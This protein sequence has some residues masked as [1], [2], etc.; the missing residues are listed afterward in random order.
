M[1][2]F[3][4]W[5]RALRESFV[6]GWAVFCVVTTIM[7]VIIAVLQHR[8]PKLS[9][10]TLFNLPLFKIISEYQ[11]EIQIAIALLFIVPYIFYAPYKLYRA[12]VH[13]P[14]KV[15]G[16]IYSVITGRVVSKSGEDAGTSIAVLLEIQN[17]GEPTTPSGF[18][19]ILKIGKQTIKLK[20]EFLP[21]DKEF[22]FHKK[23][24]AKIKRS[25]MLYEKL[26]SPIPQGGRLV[27]FLWYVAKGVKM[28]QLSD[29]LDITIIF[30][31]TDENEYR[32]APKWPASNEEIGPQ[33]V[34]G[35]ENPFIP[36]SD[37]RQTTTD[38]TQPSPTP[39]KEA[40][41]P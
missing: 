3:K 7:P 9:E 8:F 4:F 33:Y 10:F 31:D 26:S 38:T 2:F 20:P 5:A 30:R 39:N 22:E 17:A 32:A 15:R 18:E 21:E 6:W 25:E 16:I 35:V 37:H 41:P 12:D 1:E 13:T 23:G 24:T 28:S 11:A 36:F 19:A 27:G 40:S 34:P 14:E 29:H